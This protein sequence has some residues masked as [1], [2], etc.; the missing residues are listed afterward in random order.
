MDFALNSNYS[1]HL[2]DRNDLATVEGLAAFEQAVVVTLTDLMHDNLSEFSP[3][4]IEQRLH[5][6][7]TRTARQHDAIDSIATLTIAPDP[8]SPDTYRVEVHYLVDR[9]VFTEWVSL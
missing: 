4:T 2:D 7:V 3:E 8:D 5:L 6:Q 9:A 1:V